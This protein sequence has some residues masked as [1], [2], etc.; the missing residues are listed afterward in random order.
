M[1]LIS[2]QLLINTL[3]LPVELINIVKEYTFHKI[4]KI[5]K[6][7]KRYELLL[8]IPIIEN[9]PYMGEMDYVYLSITD[10]KFY[11]LVYSTDKIQLQTLLY[12]DNNEVHFIDGQ[13]IPRE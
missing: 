4:K 7:D 9:Y 10:D 13:M 1:S 5:P 6:T 12:T 8:T 3:N 2:K 11:F